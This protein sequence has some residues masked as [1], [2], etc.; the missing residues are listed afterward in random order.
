MNK[1][2]PVGSLATAT[3]VL[4]AACIQIAPGDRDPIDEPGEPGTC[5]PVAETRACSPLVWT[6]EYSI[7]SQADL[8]ALARYTVVTGDVRFERDVFKRLEGPRCLR[9]VGGSLNID[10]DQICGFD[11][12]SAIGADLTFV[13]RRQDIEIQ[14]F[15]RLRTIAGSFEAASGNYTIRGFDAL[16][17]IG[18]DL[19]GVYATLDLQG[20]NKLAT[21]GGL[22]FEGNGQVTLDGLTSL[23][24]VIG[25]ARFFDSGP[26]SLAGLR[27]LSMIGGDL[28]VTDTSLRDGLFSGLGKLEIIGGELS[29]RSNYNLRQLDAF[30]RLEVIGGGLWLDDNPNLELVR[31][32]AALREIGGGLTIGRMEDL[33]RIEGLPRL[34]RIGGSLRI[35]SNH[36]L[37]RVALR[38]LEAIGGELDISNNARLNELGLPDL[39]RLG[40]ALTIAG[41]PRLP[42]CRAEQVLDQLV[43]HGYAGAARIEGNGSGACD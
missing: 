25:T 39:T 1:G 34:E 36:R 4:C 27:S 2:Y 20:M 16:E 28:D 18:G 21:V 14:G 37:R 9:L 3:S 24:A 5:P 35:R 42:T 29:I 33:S 7:G 6:G 10:A 11:E 38:A 12:L 19:R 26:V 8:D 22:L 41:N 30:P 40:G 17:Y 31:G 43:E 13:S 32:F 23:D 15:A